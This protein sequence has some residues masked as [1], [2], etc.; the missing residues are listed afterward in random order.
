[1]IK[2]GIII[3]LVISLMTPFTGCGDAAEIDDNVY[4]VTIGLDKGIYNKLIVT[5]QYPTYK[6]GEG[7]AATA[8]G[9]SS[10]N[11]NSIEAPDPVE[12]MNLLNMVISRRVSLKH[13]KLLVISEELA[14]KG[15]AQYISAL[16][17]YREPR[18]SMAMVV[19]NGKAADFINENK[20][21]IGGSITKAIELMQN[22]SKDTGFFPNVQLH[23]FYQSVFSSYG[24]GFTAYAGV[25][26][27]SELSTTKEAAKPYLNINPNYQPG[28]L[29][30]IGVLKREFVGTAVFD[31]DK[32]VGSLNP[33]ETRA[34]LLITNKFRRGIFVINDKRAPQDAVTFE[35][36]T[37][38][39]T[40]VKFSFINGRP[41][42]NVILNVEGDI[43][44]IQ[45]RINYEDIKLIEDLDS[46]IEEYLRK[47]IEDTIIKTQKKFKADI[48]QFGYKAAAYFPTIQQWE[49]Y[50]WNSH[51][52]EAK[53]NIYVK[54]N[55]RRTGLKVKTPT[56]FSSEGKR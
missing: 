3:I 5:I 19:T 8:G 56:I 33:W 47:N 42:I 1:M 10:T 44:G 9:D 12:A 4:A 13:T 39:K 38:R 43:A 23:E 15:I 37:A 28:A 16:F 6:G 17:R 22:Q 40:R 34:F 49:A 26:N 31:G 24:Q 20:S 14:R 53:I 32:M 36:K 25:N 21:N 52:S 18:R 55:I 46:Q 54:V 48:F 30:R 41:V 51:Y 35:L 11:I 29:P 45:S 2:R 7:G 50:N 27:F